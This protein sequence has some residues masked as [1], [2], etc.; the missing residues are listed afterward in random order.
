MVVILYGDKQRVVLVSALGV[1]A[2][3]VMSAVMFDYLKK[4]ITNQLG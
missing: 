3:G 1:Q 4:I 2:R